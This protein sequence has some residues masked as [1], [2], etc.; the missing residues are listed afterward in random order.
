MKR[1]GIIVV[2]IG[3]LSF[4]STALADEVTKHDEHGRAGH[5]TVQELQ[6]PAKEEMTSDMQM[7]GT[8]SH[9]M[10]MEEH[11]NM[12]MDM[13]MGTS[14]DSVGPNTSAESGGHGGHG[15]HG[16]EIVVET[17]PNIPVLSTF[18]GIMLASI[19]YGACRKWLLKKGRAQA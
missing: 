5:E 19:L 9:S 14:K 4:V 7:D 8:N 16:E 11:Q 18:A 15:G 1:C 12:N 6:N 13:D 2:L 3:L 10:T 17:P